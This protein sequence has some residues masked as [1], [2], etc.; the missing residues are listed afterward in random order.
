MTVT[1]L[2]VLSCLPRMPMM[3]MAVEIAD[4]TG[5]SCDSVW[6]A[7]AGLREQL[8]VWSISDG[9]ELWFGV[10]RDFWPMAMRLAAKAQV[11]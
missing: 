2:A 3:A 9:N 6:L 5:L 7:I 1:E 11:T 4:D 10:D 8:Q